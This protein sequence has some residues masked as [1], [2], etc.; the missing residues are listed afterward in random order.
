ME[1]SVNVG[2]LLLETDFKKASN[3]DPRTGSPHGEGSAP[4]SLSQFTAGSIAA[5]RRS[6]YH[7]GLG[8]F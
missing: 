6:L 4:T 8:V 2:T 7:V 1:A 5:L 3:Q